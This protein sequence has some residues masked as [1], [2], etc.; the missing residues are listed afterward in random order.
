M[1]EQEAVCGLDP[2][3]SEQ[4]PMASFNAQITNIYVSTKGVNFF[5]S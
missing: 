4:L 1:P 5:T 2:S 3:T